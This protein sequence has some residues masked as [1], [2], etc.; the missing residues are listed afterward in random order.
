MFRFANPDFLYLLIALPLLMAIYYLAYRIRKRAIRKFGDFEVLKELMPEAS[1]KRPLVKAI[2]LC[3][4]FLSLTFAMARPQLGAKL[5]EVKRRGVEL[6]IALD[7]SNSM[8]ARD[9]SPNRLERA[10]QAIA[11]LV[12]RLSDDR[13]GLIVFAGDAYVQL[14]VTSDYVSAK[15]FLGSINPGMVPTQGTSIGKAID[16]A[17]NS[18]SEQNQ[19]GRTLIIITDGENHEDDALTSAKRAANNGI[20]IHTIG[21]GKPQ[22]SPIPVSTG[23]SAFLTDSDGKIV[24][25]KLD[26]D[27]L[28]SIASATGGVYTL[29]NNSNFGLNDVLAQIRKMDKQEFS[30]KVY[31]EYD[32]K[33]LYFLWFALFLLFVEF[34]I[35]ERKNRWQEKFEFFKSRLK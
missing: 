22:G 31:S 23:S 16:L 11:R 29:A 35:L 20:I 12:D 18:F 6:V 17:V 27:I 15:M 24:M 5:K 32:E 2:M 1:S 25:S 3:L 33:F 21:I 4:V 9:I 34:F 14:P 28:S 8:L 30:S 26:E 10:K 7:V 13:I 19:K